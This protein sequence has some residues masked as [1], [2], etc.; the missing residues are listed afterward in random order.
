MAKRPKAIKYDP[1]GYS[2]PSPKPPVIHELQIQRRMGNWTDDSVKRTPPKWLL[3]KLAEESITGKYRTHRSNL[4][5]DCFT[6][7]SVGGACQCPS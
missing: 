3:D 5:P 2:T 1:N 4:C 7:R 6:F